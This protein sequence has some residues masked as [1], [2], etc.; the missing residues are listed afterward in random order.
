MIDYHSTLVKTLETVLPT[1]YELVLTSKTKTPCISYME[2][3][4]YQVVAG[5]SLGYSRASYTITVWADGIGKVQEYALQIDEALRPIGWKRTSSGELYDKSTGLVRKIMN[6][7]A[8]V[9]E[10]YN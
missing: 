3:N 9:Q 8:L 4:N 10:H 6:Y 1:H 2:N 5:H 7:E